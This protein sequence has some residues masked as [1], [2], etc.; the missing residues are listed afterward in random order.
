MNSSLN[1]I[2]QL[3]T[4]H[5]RSRSAFPI[6]RKPS[7]G[8][9][10]ICERGR[11]ID[12]IGKQV[13]FVK[14]KSVAESPPVGGKRSEQ[15]E[16]E[17]KGNQKISLTDMLNSDISAAEMKKFQRNVIYALNRLI[18]EAEMKNEK[19]IQQKNGLSI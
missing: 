8:T 13:G 5:A 6:A 3:K 4:S 16:T 1:I 7:M 19:N 10:R 2:E 15:D 18:K 9:K 17:V 14:S 12:A 11:S